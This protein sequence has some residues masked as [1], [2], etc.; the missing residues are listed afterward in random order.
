MLY[1]KLTDGYDY[2]VRNDLRD[3]QA[4]HKEMR[5]DELDNRVEDAQLAD[6]VLSRHDEIIVCGLYVYATLIAGHD[7]LDSHPRVKVHDFVQFVCCFGGAVH[8]LAVL[9]VTD[10]PKFVKR[11][12]VASSFAMNPQNTLN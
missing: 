4:P 6:F 9:V 8:L 12:H 10:A 5:D 3:A 11:S 2:V 1:G 7:G